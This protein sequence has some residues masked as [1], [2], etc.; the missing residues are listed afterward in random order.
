VPVDNQLYDRLSDTWWDENGFLNILRAAL[1]PVR[2]GYMRGVLENTLGIDPA[3]RRTL[4]VGCGGGLLAE[5]FA[6]LGCQVTGID[7]SEPSLETARAHAEQ[8]GLEIDYRRGVGEQLPFEDAFFDTVYCCD[9]LEHVDD[10]ARVIAESARVLR[11]GGIYLYDTLNRTL[12]SRVIAIKVWQEWPSTAFMEPN[13]HD[14]RM[15]IKP[16]ELQA[17]LLDNALA[18]GPIQGIA[19]GINPVA[20]IHLL[21]QRARGEMNYAEFGR[22]IQL[23]ESRDRSIFYAGYAVRAA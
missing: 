2:F 11:P 20:M 12:P 16:R 6:R 17:L 8:S 22:R 1:N 4:D 15:F 7:P 18:P 21:R 9:V 3:G 13:L 10:L 23:R 5:E 14:W 19:P